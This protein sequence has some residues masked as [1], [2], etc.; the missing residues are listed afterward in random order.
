V[1]RH[2]MLWELPLRRVKLDVAV[3]VITNLV[4]KRIGLGEC[5]DRRRVLYRNA[6]SGT[7]RIVSSM[8]TSILWRSCD[9]AL[10]L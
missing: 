5:E 6:G 10:A 8:K 1:Q 4:K 9:H 3:N 7:S 2:L